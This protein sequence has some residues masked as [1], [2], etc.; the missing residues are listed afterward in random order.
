MKKAKMMMAMALLM[1]VI[2]IP[3]FVSA[4]MQDNQAETQDISPLSKDRGEEY[5]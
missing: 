4:D 5:D 1:A 3:G 2:G